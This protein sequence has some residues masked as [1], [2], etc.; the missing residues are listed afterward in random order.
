MPI[1]EKQIALLLPELVGIANVADHIEFL[2]ASVPTRL[3]VVK[4]GM[5]AHAL[6]YNQYDTITLASLIEAFP[7]HTFLQALTVEDLPVLAQALKDAYE[8]DVDAHRA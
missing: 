3:Q 6:R 8:Q 2:D 5:A 4:L 7:T 1:T